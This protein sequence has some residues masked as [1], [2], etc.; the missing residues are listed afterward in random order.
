[1]ER[2]KVIQYFYDKLNDYPPGE[3]G[4]QYE[5][6]DTFITLFGFIDRKRRLSGVQLAV[7][8]CG[9]EITRE[10]DCELVYEIIERLK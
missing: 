9:V 6:G 4:F 1:M 2:Q 5:Y 3:F 10:S 7:Y 8:E